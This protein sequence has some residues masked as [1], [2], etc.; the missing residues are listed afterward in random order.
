[1][2]IEGNYK[3][4]ESN[5]I[6]GGVSSSN[7]ERY[8]FVYPNVPWIKNQFDTRIIYSDMHVTD[9]FKNGYRVFGDQHHR[10]YTKNYGTITKL[11]EWSGN[12]ICV[13]EHGVLLIPVNERVL[14]GDGSG[15]SVYINTNNVLP[16]NPLVISSTF[17]STW[18]ESIVKTNHYVYGVDTVGKKIWRTEG[19]QLEVI[20]DFKV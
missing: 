8:N 4:P 15:G 18:I 6:S 19:K 11:I 12:L 14:A 5:L 17:G 7:S 16:E 1:M 10:D 13:C 3:I 9:A 20:S 2:T